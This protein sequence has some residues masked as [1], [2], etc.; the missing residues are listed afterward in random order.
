LSRRNVD[1]AFVL[2]FLFM[3][4]FYGAVVAMIKPKESPVRKAVDNA[5]ANN[6]VADLAGCNRL[7]CPPVLGFLVL[8]W[9]IS[10]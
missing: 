6:P 3:A 9:V 7:E 1:Q 8:S 5:S 10:R 2:R 4:N